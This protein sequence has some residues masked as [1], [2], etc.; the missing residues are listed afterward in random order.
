MSGTRLGVG[1]PTGVAFDWMESFMA[2][3]TSQ[4]L[5]ANEVEARSVMC[6]C[7]A[8][9]IIKHICVHPSHNNKFYI[10]TKRREENRDVDPGS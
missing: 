2:Y 1:V 8:F 10:Q 3:L 7:K 6:C 9:T 5:L 4:K